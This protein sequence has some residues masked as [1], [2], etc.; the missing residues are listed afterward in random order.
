MKVYE[1]NVKL[2]TRISGNIKEKV[3]FLNAVKLEEKPMIRK[4]EDS[5]EFFLNNQYYKVFSMQPEKEIAY[6]TRGLQEK[7]DYLIVIF[8]VGN[9]RL[10]HEVMNKITK[11][12]RILIFEPNPYLLK[13]V[14]QNYDLSFLLDSN[15]VGLIFEYG[16]QHG[17]EQEIFNYGV[18]QWGNLI[19]NLCVIAPP[20]SYHYR[21]KCRYIMKQFI[22][23]IDINIKKLG[24]C[25]EDILNGQENNYKNIDAIIESN[26][27]EEIKNKFV[28]YPAIIVASGPSLDKNINILHEAQDKALI[29]A[30]DASMNACKKYG[31]KPDA[32]A[33]IERDI[34]TYQYYYK[35]KS[36]DDDL[37]LVGPSLLWPQIF[38][39]FAGKKIIT[40]K[41]NTGIEKW[42]KDNFK[43]FEFLNQGMSSANVAFAYAKA[44]GCN[45]IILIGQDLAYTANKKHS[46]L[47]HTEF[48]GENDSSESDGL[49]TEDIYGN[50]V[51]TDDI[52]NMFRSWF[53]IQIMMNKELQ[54][55]DAT[56]GG[57]KIHGSEIMT[58]RE[59]IDKYCKKEMEIHLYDCLSDNGELEALVYIKQ[60]DHVIREAKK[61]QKRLKELKQKAEKHYKVLEQ[62]YYKEKLEEMSEE[63][64]I[65]VLLKM[66][67]GDIIIQDIQ[68]EEYLLTYFQQMIRQT[69]IFVK[70][71]G[72]EI[73]PKN[74]KQ[75]IRFQANLMGVIKN[76]S[77]LIIEEYEKMITFIKEKK[78]KR[79]GEINS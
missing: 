69:I 36:F 23:A 15:Q 72:N 47:T 53:E 50:L 45:P 33:S 34:P 28:G 48:E 68:K 19:K 42:W 58:L 57:A 55:I 64:L 5:L 51:L 71:L 78:E 70:A 75:N 20:N 43:S 63:K 77:N 24:N 10:L 49:M 74:V 32:V 35:D 21:E 1:N 56:E 40:S 73:T 44:A 25:L 13:Y 54:V 31:V 9:L 22:S 7:K 3:D 52:Y 59:S 38:E 12:S 62:I 46:K 39:D 79:E 4:L 30:C 66:Q 61:Q 27:L 37:V 6:L 11:E 26:K 67:K 8:G 65:Q 17:L 29:I 18:L 76:S 14:L 16:S 2:L 60:Y 41:V